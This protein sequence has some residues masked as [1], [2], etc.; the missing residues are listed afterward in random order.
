MS[1]AATAQAGASAAAA[2]AGSRRSCSTRTRV[3]WSHSGAA[4]LTRAEIRRNPTSGSRQQRISPTNPGQPPSLA[5]LP[6]RRCCSAGQRADQH[7]TAIQRSPPRTQP[8]AQVSVQTNITP[9][10]SALHRAHSR[11][12][13]AMQPV[14][15]PCPALCRRQRLVQR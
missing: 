12:W 14:A 6:T 2:A 5:R 13:T 4:G 3:L 7:H 15:P 9:P 10:S 1:A 11:R 8:A